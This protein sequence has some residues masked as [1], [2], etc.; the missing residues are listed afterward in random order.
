[1]SDTDI[2]KTL[3]SFRRQV[4]DIDDQLLSLLVRRVAIVKEIGQMKK[5]ESLP[6]FDPAREA[7]NK[8]R[9]RDIGVGHL[10]EPMIDEFTDFLSNW[11]REIQKMLR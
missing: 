6:I 7:F 4:R 11:A 9:N 1:M 10:P 5:R 8:G 3:E 2:D